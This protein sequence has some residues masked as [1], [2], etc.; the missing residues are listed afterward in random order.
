MDRLC[1]PAQGGEGVA[2][3]PT[4]GDVL[5]AFLASVAQCLQLA[6]R[7]LRVLRL[8]AVCGLPE[9]GANLYRCC[10]CGKR[11][12]AP[13]SCGDRHCP[14]CLAAKSREWL[15]KQL[16]SLLPI[17]YYHGVFTLPSELHALVLL[18][19]TRLYPLLFQ[20][21]T[22]ALMEFG[23]NRLGGDLGITALL[24]TWGQQL[25]FHPHLHCIVTG[26]AL[27]RDGR[28]WRSPKQRK[29]LFPIRAVAV[30][31]R[32]KFLH[33]LEQLLQDPKAL[34]LPENFP[35]AGSAR[36]RWFSERYAQRWIVYAKRPFGGPQQVLAYLANY[37]HRVAISDRRI[38]ALDPQAR[39]VTFTYRDYRHASQ[40]KTC[41]LSSVEF[42]RRFSHHILPLGLV[43]I[44]HY[45]IL[46]NNRRHRDIPCARS[47]LERRGRRRPNLVSPPALPSPNVTR[48][49]PHCGHDQ[50]R[51]LG[52]LDARGHT[53]LNA[54]SILYD[55]S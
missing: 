38:L 39:T 27:R 46:G 36:R 45:G 8:L 41:T 37:T 34:R 29:F 6:A 53:H 35:I 26:G 17:T 47:I 54:A 15:D 52:Y 33:G 25:N 51:W 12:F 22:A 16:G 4:L 11:H 42:I 20:C 14:R 30:L 31:F 40:V 55:S 28:G 5:R 19:P 21:A 13:R 10:A 50:L 9:L 2:A 24:H 18:N 32:G 23:A 49:C 7:P 44:R 48:C 3:S 1:P 43:R